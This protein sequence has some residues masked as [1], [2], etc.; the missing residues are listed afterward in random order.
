MA[1]FYFEAYNGASSLAAVK[2]SVFRQ[3]FEDR[4]L[5]ENWPHFEKVGG[6][7]GLA[8]LTNKG[9]FTSGI[10]KFRVDGWFYL[11]AKDQD[12][13]FSTNL[14]NANGKITANA[15]IAAD[16][17][18]KL[19][20]CSADGKVLAEKIISGDSTEIPVFDTVPAGDFF[21]R[22][23]MKNAKLYTLNF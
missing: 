15:E 20:L 4:G 10:I 11:Q 2:G 22:G 9:G 8:K 6:Y 23:T 1:H 13:T 3:R 14:M 18:I 16:G 5:A 17:F 7:D 21:I 12:G 19:E